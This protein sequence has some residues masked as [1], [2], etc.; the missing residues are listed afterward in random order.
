[1]VSEEEKKLITE[2][3]FMSPVPFHL[4]ENKAKHMGI[5]MCCSLF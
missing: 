1:M 4:A 5:S 2:I 3:S